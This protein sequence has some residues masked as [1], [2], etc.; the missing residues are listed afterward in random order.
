MPSRPE[1]MKKLTSSR[2][3]R[4]TKHPATSKLTH[5]KNSTKLIALV[6]SLLLAFVLFWMFCLNH[7][8]ISHVGIAYDSRSGALTA[9]TNAG[10]YMTSPF[11]RV[12]EVSILPA[13]ISIDGVSSSR[14]VINDKIVRYVLDSES[15]K[16]LVEY[17]GFHYQYFAHHLTPYAYSGKKYSFFEILQES[18]TSNVSTNK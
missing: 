8:S 6:S 12:S 2:R 18:Q 3:S 15:I 14:I 16:E 11:V 13:R 7:V 17:E 9:Q 5:M 10:W 4:L 1:K